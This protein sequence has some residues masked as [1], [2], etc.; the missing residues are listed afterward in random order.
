MI[1]GYNTFAGG[2]SGAALSYI[3][4]NTLPGRLTDE[5]IGVCIDQVTANKCCSLAKAL[6]NSYF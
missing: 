2:Y 3:D 1:G 6:V 4:P 5:D